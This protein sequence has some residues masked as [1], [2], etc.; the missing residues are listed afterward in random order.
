MK[1]VVD[2]SVAFKWAVR[3][4]DSDKADLLRAGR[5]V[6]T[7]TLNVVQLNTPVDEKLFARPQN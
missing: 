2:S 6:L 3:E 4:V 1:Y 7:R 5:V